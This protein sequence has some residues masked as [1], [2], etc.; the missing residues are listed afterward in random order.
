MGELGLPLETEIRKEP[1]ES[2]IL[3]VVDK[4]HAA[5]KKRR[6]AKKNPAGLL[7]SRHGDDSA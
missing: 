1:E 3:V 4:K 6:G 5:K 2:D 7:S